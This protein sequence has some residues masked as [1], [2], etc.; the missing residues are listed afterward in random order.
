[1]VFVFGMISL[2]IL[3]FLLGKEMSPFSDSS[4]IMKIQSF[5]Q[6]GSSFLLGLM[7]FGL[8][9][10]SSCNICDDV[11]AFLALSVR[12]DIALTRFFS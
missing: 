6:K 9:M 4:F 5:V 1:M 10:D 7:C 12:V 3:G 11:H 2:S 8:S